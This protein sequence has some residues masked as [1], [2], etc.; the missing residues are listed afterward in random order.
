MSI[1]DEV[2]LTWKG[3]EYVVPP[4]KV[5]GLVEVVEDVITIEELAANGVKR[6]KVAKA[7]A[8]AI[9][10]AAQCQGAVAKIDEQDVYQS[11]FGDN[12][13]AATTQTVYGLL[14]FMIPPEHLQ[15]KPTQAKTPAKK[16]AAKGSSR[17]RT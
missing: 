1:F 3:K 7:F 17:K 12:A 2:G 13:M 14:S 10:Y 4:D 8:A 16:K 5:M 11:L 9:R 15:T 6:A